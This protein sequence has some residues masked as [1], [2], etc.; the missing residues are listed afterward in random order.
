MPIE[1]FS[2]YVLGPRNQFNIEGDMYFQG[3]GYILERR[4]SGIITPVTINLTNLEIEM[5]LNHVYGR[6]DSL[7][8]EQE[9]TLKDLVGRIMSG[10]TQ[11]KR[12]HEML[13]IK[14]EIRDGK[15]KGVHRNIMQKGFSAELI[16]RLMISREFVY[17][18]AE[19][20]FL[21]N[22]G[23][24]PNGGSPPNPKVSGINW[25]YE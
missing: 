10:N 4:I 19:K 7:T 20:S 5:D 15:F 13:M 25:K 8:K 11:R 23:P 22:G 1:R 2:L 24:I 16:E 18:S 17:A 6:F 14:R 12:F 21:V 3:D 9:S